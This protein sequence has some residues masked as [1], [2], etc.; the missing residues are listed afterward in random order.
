M[1]LAA[2]KLW[3][4]SWRSLSLLALNMIES[5]FNAVDSLTIWCFVYFVF[6]VQ[7]V[8]YFVGVSNAPKP[9]FHGEHVN[10]DWYM[11]ELLFITS[12]KYK[13]PFQMFQL[14]TWVSGGD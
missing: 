11:L 1:Q 6:F 9:Y 14:R 8:K 10:D 13:D 2:R 5:V 7:K 12:E 4:A 3:E